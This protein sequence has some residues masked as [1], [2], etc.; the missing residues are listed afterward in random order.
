MKKPVNAAAEYIVINTS[1]VKTYLNDEQKQQLVEICTVIGQQRESAGIEPLRG[2][3]V[4]EHNELFEYVYYYM[5][6]KQVLAQRKGKK[7]KGTK[8]TNETKTDIVDSKSV[9]SKPE[10]V[11]KPQYTSPFR[12]TK[13]E[14]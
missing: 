11:A 9:D 6:G 5:V 3:F 1:D 7:T 10:P 12:K 2:I 13:Q 14:K 4:D 8:G